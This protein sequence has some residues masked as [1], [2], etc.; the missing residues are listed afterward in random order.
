MKR[1]LIPVLP[2][3]LLL[4]LAGVAP[5]AEAPRLSARDLLRIAGGSDPIPA[6]W[7]GI[8][9]TVDSVYNCTGG[10]QSTSSSTDTLCTGQVI[11]PEPDPSFEYDCTGTT[12]PTTVNMTCTGR[13]EVFQDC[14]A[15]YVVTIV[16]TRTN[17]S[18]FMVATINTTFSGTGEGC[19][20]LPDQ[21]L[22]INSHGT[23]TAPEP[24]E[25]CATPVEETTWGQ[26]KSL[27]R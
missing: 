7:A 8:W 27:Y 5:A 18:Y 10:L 13:S 20:F 1:F 25:Y 15:D 3:V 11:E 23:R 26:V 16:G 21:C 2:A 6:Q 17:D 24:T 19:D 22:Q 12:T 9:D 14:F 4:A